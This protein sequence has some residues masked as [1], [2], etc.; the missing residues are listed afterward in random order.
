MSVPRGVGNIKYNDSAGAR[1]PSR[2]I[3]G[4]YCTFQSS[5]AEAK[6]SRG[7][8]SRGSAHVSRKSRAS[9]RHPGSAS[10]RPASNLPS[11]AG[12]GSPDPGAR[13][14]TGSGSRAPDGSGPGASGTA[15]SEP[16][17]VPRGFAAPVK[18]SF[19]QLHQKAAKAQP[20]RGSVTQPPPAWHPDEVT[21][22]FATV[23]DA[24]GALHELP[25]PTLLATILV[26]V[27]ADRRRLVNRLV[28][29]SDEQ[30]EAVANVFWPLIV[31]PGRQEP[32]IA[33]FDGTGVWARAFRYTMLPSMD[34]V[35]SQLG[36]EVP[37]PEFLERMRRLTPYFA[38]DPGTEVL[39][40]E[41][42]LPIDPPLLFDI[43]SQSDVRS[44]P[45]TPH[46]GFLPARR[47]MAWYSN[48]VGEMFRWLDRFDSD[49]RTLAGVRERTQQTIS[50]AERRLDEEFRRLQVETQERAQQA[51]ARSEQEI[52]AMQARRRQAIQQHVGAIR[53]AQTVVAHAQSSAATADALSFRSSHRRTA[54]EPHQLRRKQAEDAI[55]AANLE[56]AEARKE[57]ERIH[58][59]ERAD[60]ET[61][62]LNAG[63]V[64]QSY[65]R[66]LSDR[67]LFRDEFSAAGL[68]LLHSIDGQIAARSAQKN[69]LA[70]YF[71][72][73]PSLAGVRVVWF[74]L[75]IATLRGPRGIRQIVFPPMQVRRQMKWKGAL[76]QAFGGVVL[77]VEPRTAQFDEVLRTTMEEALRKDPWLST[78]T[79][80]LT[81][82]A[83]VLVD[84]DL[85]HRLQQGLR[86]L[87]REGWITPKQEKSFLAAYVHR[88]QARAGL[89]VGSPAPIPVGAA[90]EHYTPG[91]APMA[92][93]GNAPGR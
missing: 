19:D 45:Q 32:E 47:E 22:G 75:W 80:E 53:H 51:A 78:A 84:P 2:G 89:P 49:L 7:R 30:I 66:A 85:L 40:V 9:R 3:I 21:L 60:I 26:A 72:P 93:S 56:A 44:D 65:A 62:I 6:R 58:A 88:S 24:D 36:E 33:I 34:H 31:L 61:A 83:D 86:D 57:I 41:G 1:F 74:P 64:E 5:V 8:A 70:G 73:V 82:A 14:P 39:N 23:S 25:E 43:L 13:T 76:K 20:R 37:S 91:T 16:R 46:A 10:L 79:Q 11:A 52:A 59:A 71:L 77:P 63:Q 12:P 54:G 42:F 55:R 87:G 48:T 29:G 35:S 28:G 81:R 67:E 17:P 4:G 69:L 38:Q 68:D 92:S 15:R 27:E 50:A 90:S 18:E